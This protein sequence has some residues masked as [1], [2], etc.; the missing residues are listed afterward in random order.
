MRHWKL[1]IAVLALLAAL[2]ACGG[3]QEP[4]AAPDP[5]PAPAEDTNTPAAL[6]AQKEEDPAA[7]VQQDPA[8]AA[9]EGEADSKEDEAVEPGQ[10]PPE[11]APAQ[12]PA[13]SQPEEPSADKPD[14]KPDEKPAEEPDAEPA[15]EENPDTPSSA[16]PSAAPE[17]SP[18]PAAPAADPKAAAQGLIGRPVSELYA[19]IGQPIS[20]DYAPSCLVEG[21]DGE[22]LYDGFTVYTTRT[23]DSE[24]VYDVF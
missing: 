14:E 6:D 2:C 21:E 15:P 20:S 18:E 19:A 24:T 16:E 13:E 7:P 11:Q 8:G 22:L 23:A 12:E 10:D 9:P 5:A 1:L 17:T 3:A 4:G